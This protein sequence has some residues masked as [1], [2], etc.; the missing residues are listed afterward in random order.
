MKPRMMPPNTYGPRGPAPPPPPQLIMQ[1]QQQPIIYDHNS[2]YRQQQ[3]PPPPQHIATLQTNSHINDSLLNQSKHPHQQQ[4]MPQQVL[5]LPSGMLTTDDNILKSL[6]QINPQAN[7]EEIATL[8]ARTSG[9]VMSN[10]ISTDNNDSYDNSQMQIHDNAPHA[11]AN[12]HHHHLYNP[13]IN[14][15]SHPNPPPQSAPTAKI[16]KPR[17]K[18][19]PNEMNASFDEDVPA[20]SRKRKKKGT[21]ETEKFV[22]HS[23]QQLRDL[24]MLTPLEPLIDISSEL[25]L[26]LPIDLPDKK[27]QYQGEFG[28]VFIETIND[29][30]RPQRRPPPKPV[31]ATI[32]ANSLSALERRYRI[33][34]TLL[35]HPPR[36]PSPPLAMDSNDK[37][38]GL[39]TKEENHEIRDDESIISTSTLAE[40][41]T[42]LNNIEMENNQ[43]LKTLS[44]NNDYRSLSPVFIS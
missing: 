12:N 38:S 25:S 32:P 2:L 8:K 30:Y 19:K 43:L 21:E 44:S 4:P 28:N 3:P 42:I 18:R 20:K 16:P 24:P 34:S 7:S 15:P 14:T 23:L 40:D 26:S 33:C 41:D 22:E 9:N 10:G 29:Y 6:L 31:S 1:Q 17:K 13:P 37:L 11:Y 5:H 35:D 36:L 27:Y 39:L